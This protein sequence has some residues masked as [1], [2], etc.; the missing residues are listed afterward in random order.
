MIIISR[1]NIVS[2]QIFGAVVSNCFSLRYFVVGR[3]V[4][5]NDI[6]VYIKLMGLHK[7]AIIPNPILI[8]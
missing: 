3:E 4:T 5:K 6:C 7:Q 8:G 2:K 1:S